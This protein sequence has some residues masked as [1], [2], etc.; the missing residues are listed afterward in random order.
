MIRCEYC[1]T[2]NAE[3]E[4]RCVQCGAPLLDVPIRAKS[5]HMTLNEARAAQ[6]L[7]PIFQVGLHG[8]VKYLVVSPSTDSTGGELMTDWST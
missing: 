4:A 8:P 6:N 5:P 7:Q 3:T 1:A 2:K